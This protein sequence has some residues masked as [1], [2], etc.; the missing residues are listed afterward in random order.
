MRSFT[1][2]ATMPFAAMPDGEMRLLARAH[3]QADH[4]VPITC[5]G[6]ASYAN[7]VVVEI[8]GMNKSGLLTFH[9]WLFAAFG[10]DLVVQQ[11]T[12]LLVSLTADE[13]KRLLEQ[14]RQ[15]IDVVARID[16]KEELEA[17][18]KERL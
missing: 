12:G 1:V 11:E 4:Y 16:A 9:E 5:S 8:A 2:Y 10:R 14:L 6:A 13:R 17:M 15:A 3:F 18:L 7:R